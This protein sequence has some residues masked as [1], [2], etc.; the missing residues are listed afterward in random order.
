ML[1]ARLPLLSLIATTLFN[2]RP[3]NT[4]AVNQR[5]KKTF[6]LLKS[7]V[8]FLDCLFRQ[9][10]ETS[11]RA[12][13]RAEAKANPLTSLP[14]WGHLGDLVHRSSCHGGKRSSFLCRGSRHLQEYSIFILFSAS[15]K[16]EQLGSC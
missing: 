13:T 8:E 16:C 4:V 1:R 3:K 10:Q 2:R 7:L 14:S 5:M 11:Q 15:S 9:Q 6:Y 12:W